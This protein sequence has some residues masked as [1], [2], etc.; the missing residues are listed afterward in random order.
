M[1]LKKRMFHSNMLILGLAVMVLFLTAGFVAVMFEGKFARDFESMEYAKLDENVLQAVDIFDKKI[2][3]IK[4]ETES[5]QWETLQRC[6]ETQ[7]YNLT[8]IRNGQIL[9]KIKRGHSQGMLKNFKFENHKDAAPQVYYTQGLT[10]VV[11]YVPETLSYYFAVGGEEQEWW[12]GPVIRSFSTFFYAFLMLLVLMISFM[13]VLAG[14]FSRKTLARI[15]DPLEVLE[16]GAERIREGKL[17]VPVEY[18]GDEEF[19]NLCTTFNEM[20]K[21]ILDNQK[22]QIKNEQARTDMV[23]GISHDLRTPLT[24]IQGYIKGIL[25][26]VADTKEKQDRYLQ[27]A[28]DATV[29]MNILLQK[30]FDFSRIESGQLPFH[31]VKGDIGEFAAGYIA[32]KE[33]ALQGEEVIFTFYPGAEVLPDVVMDIDQIRRI[34]DNLLENSL[35]YVVS[36]PVIIEVSVYEKDNE[37]RIDWKDN[38][39]GVP[40]DKLEHIFDRFYRCDESRSKKGSGVGLYVVQWIMKQHGGYAEAINGRGLMIRLHIPLADQIAERKKAGLQVRTM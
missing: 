18:K 22:Q 17:D 24:S 1:S 27:T 25:D 12:M 6:L 3:E 30:L 28:Y 16:K 5:D 23:T 31:G 21:S 13:L 9:Y 14:Y 29:E 19:E 20:Q 36:R 2:P 35:K 32:G 8:V 26:G 4:P 7:G 39:E 38:G 11:Q 34:L 40:E 37:I 15:T 33:K 10:V